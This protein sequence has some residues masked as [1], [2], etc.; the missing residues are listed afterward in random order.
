M[1]TTECPRL[2]TV[3]VMA[4]ELGVSADRV[5]RVIRTRRH[6]RPVAYA[7]NTRLFDKAALAS[8][9]H[10]INAIDARRGKGADHA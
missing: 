10:E 6:I 1:Q 7:G 4:E 5:A 8:I 3:G 2:L 9:R